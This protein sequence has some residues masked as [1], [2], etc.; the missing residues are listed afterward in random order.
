VAAIFGPQA[1]TS[2]LHV[3]SV[4]DAKEMTHIETRWSADPHRGPTI[5]IHPHPDTLSKV[6]ID[7]VTDWEWK[8]F[9]ILYESASYLPFTS[10]LLK[11][12]DR[13]G[14][15]VSVEQLNLKD[16]G[17]YRSVLQRV[18]M[19]EEKNIVLH[20]SIDILPEVLKQAQ[21]VGIMTE[22]H[23]YFITSLDM[24]TIDLE[25]YQYSGTNITGVR[26]IDPEDPYIQHITN[27][28]NMS[29]YLNS[30]EISPGLT[31]AQMR[32]ETALMF[33]SVYLFA[34][35]LKNFGIELKNSREPSKFETMSMK[36][37]D[38]TTWKHGLSLYNYIKMVS[39]IGVF[40][41]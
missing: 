30:K 17:N 33:D 15:T 24:H 18:K 5:N 40:T 25:P 4:C 27:F 20:C 9:T 6:F 39:P 41:R 21:Q 12:Y 28:F 13:N 37:K 26:L 38:Q 2:A 34:E 29:E 36:C 23:Q 14:Y 31:A 35:A 7:M 32:V 11:Y 19:T 22:H 16:D 3:Q 10:D 1:P 8:S